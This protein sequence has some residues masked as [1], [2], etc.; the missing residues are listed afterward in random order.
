MSLIKGAPDPKF[1]LIKA[2]QSDEVITI[3]GYTDFDEEYNPDF[4]RHEMQE[5]GEIKS[6]L[7]GFRYRATIYFEK[8]NGSNLIG[9][10]KIF[11]RSGYDTILFYPNSVDKPLYSVDITIDDDTVKLA[12]FYLLAQ[13]DFSCK[14]MGRKLVDSVPLVLADFLAWGNISLQFQDLNAAFS[15][16]T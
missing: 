11:N 13:K 10:S 5:E 14:V 3:N 6:K 7:R 12:Y 4:L 2:G 16:L 1:V 15:T 8:V 9:L